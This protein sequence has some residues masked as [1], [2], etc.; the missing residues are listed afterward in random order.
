MK[1]KK[2]L[3]NNF[4]FHLTKQNYF[5]KVLRSTTFILTASR[6]SRAINQ[7]ENERKELTSIS[8]VLPLYFFSALTQ[9]VCCSIYV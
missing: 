4:K 5:T 1:K 6:T 8:P 3:L 2:F 7:I 9:A